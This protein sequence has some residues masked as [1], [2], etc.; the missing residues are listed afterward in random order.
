ME[1][2]TGVKPENYK[3]MVET[4]HEFGRYPLEERLSNLV[5]ARSG[6]WS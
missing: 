2:G 3:A 4:I 6:K 5:V 1:N